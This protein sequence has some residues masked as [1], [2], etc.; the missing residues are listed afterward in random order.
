MFKIIVKSNYEEVSAEA[1]KYVR[2]LLIKKPNAVLGLATGS[3]PVGLYKCMI[4][5]NKDGITN[6]EDVVTFNL[7]E[8]IGIPQDHSQSYYTFMYENLFSQI[9]IKDEN[10]H[11][12][13]ANNDTDT[14]AC[15][16]YEELMAKY[17]VDIQVLGIGSN[18][19]I[20]FNEPGT[21]FNSTTHIVELTKRTR[22]DNQRFFDSLEEVPT[23]SITMG[24]A[25]ITRA[26]Q[27][28]MVAVGANKAQAVYDMIN[29]TMN[30]SVPASVLQQHQDVIVILDEEAS[31]KL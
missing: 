4:T 25:S 28:V 2:E 22:L 16:K 26:K 11:L 31:S 7:D 23:H 19:H 14:V 27:I 5:D 13:H 15:D 29:G 18:A 1:N 21:K 3:S 17:E 30:E 8:Y 10:V 12:P 20:G 6:F 24:I 9:N